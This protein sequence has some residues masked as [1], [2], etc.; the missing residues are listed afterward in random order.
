MNKMAFAVTKPVTQIPPERT[1]S[2]FFFLLIKC[3]F[4]FQIF[5]LS[6]LSGTC[7]V[8]N[9]QFYSTVAK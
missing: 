2:D 1:V 3:V 4:N 8:H 5:S 7:A 9:N 6:I